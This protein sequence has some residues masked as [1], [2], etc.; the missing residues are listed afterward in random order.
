MCLCANTIAGSDSLGAGNEHLLINLHK[1]NMAAN[2]PSVLYSPTTATLY[3]GC[4]TTSFALLLSAD[5]TGSFRKLPKFF[6]RLIAYLL[7]TVLKD[8]LRLYKCIMVKY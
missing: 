5:N 8:N 3:Y 7:R 2:E 6:K 1:T 4:R